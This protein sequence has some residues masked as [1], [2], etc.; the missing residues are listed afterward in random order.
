[1]YANTIALIIAI[2]GETEVCVQY[3]SGGHLPWN[4]ETCHQQRH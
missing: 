4:Q 3:P 2:P 1:M